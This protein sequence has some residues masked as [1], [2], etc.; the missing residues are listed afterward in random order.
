MADTS[1]APKPR[2]AFYESYRFWA[3]ATAVATTLVWSSCGDD[4]FNLW[5]PMAETS[6]LKSNE[7]AKLEQARVLLDEKAYDDAL[8]LLDP[9]LES[10]DSNDARILYAAAKLGKS[11]LDVWTVIKK[12][13][14]S[15]TSST[16]SSSK[17]SSSGS[18]SSGF[19]TILNN[20]TDTLIGTGEVR[21][22][23]IAALADAVTSLQAAPDPL[24]DDVRNTACILAG[25]LAVPT[26]ADATTA[27]SATLAALAQIKEA[28]Q[29]GGTVC[30][31]LTLLDTSANSVLTS[32]TNFN[33]VVSAAKSCPFIDISQTATLMNS[34]ESAIAKLKTQADKGC[35]SLPTTCPTAVPNCQELFPTCVQELL[36]VGTSSAVAGDGRVDMCEMVL[37]C[38]SPADCF[39]L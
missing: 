8:S 22:A 32:V 25:F 9:M 19:D 39:S 17:T 29:S 34:I 4:E 14:D 36:K 33:L 18:G 21:T 20:I 31:N 10:Q 2:K 7:A 30:P 28:A 38:T 12:I 35:A 5:K 16:S 26:I 11:E 15:T 24:A 23:R 3:I 13:L 27:L 37:N 1:K 6:A